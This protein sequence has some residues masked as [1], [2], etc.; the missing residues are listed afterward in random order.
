[1]QAPEDDIV[2]Q[3][4]NLKIK[5]VIDK[6]FP[7][8]LDSV[9]INRNRN[10]ECTERQA[11]VIAGYMEACNDVGTCRTMYK[12]YNSYGIAWQQKYENGWL[13]ADSILENLDYEGM[14]PL[15]WYE[16]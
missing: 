11:L 2:K 8:A 12:V 4:L 14:R 6:N 13:D 1:M 3:D 15:S 5:R 9:C 10:A 16:Y 7:I